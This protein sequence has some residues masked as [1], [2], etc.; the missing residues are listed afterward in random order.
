MYHYA[1]ISPDRDV[2][3]FFTTSYEINPAEVRSYENGQMAIVR[4][5]ADDRPALKQGETL[6]GPIDDLT[7]DT[8]YRRWRVIPTTAEQEYAQK[9]REASLPPLM[10]AVVHSLL[11][12]VRVLEGKPPLTAEQMDNWLLGLAQSLDRESK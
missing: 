10:R 11:D 7:H 4:V 1:R 12:R 3:S 5:V 6:V 8:L 9:K 2:I